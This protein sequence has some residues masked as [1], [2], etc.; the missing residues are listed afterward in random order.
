MHLSCFPGF[1]LFL[2]GHLSQEA[3]VP[4]ESWPRGSRSNSFILHIGTKAPTSCPEQLMGEA[5]HAG[6]SKVGELL[7]QRES[8]ASLEKRACCLPPLA[9]PGCLLLLLAQGL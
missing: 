3:R 1:R 6:L 7:G 2:W 8:D 9:Q 4:G 5:S